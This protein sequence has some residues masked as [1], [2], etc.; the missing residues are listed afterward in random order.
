M[1]KGQSEGGRKRK[2][3]RIGGETERAR[4][5]GESERGRGKAARE[6]GA[7]RGWKEGGEGRGAEARTRDQTP[8]LTFSAALGK[9]PIR[10]SDGDSFLSLGVQKFRKETPS[11]RETTPPTPPRAPAQSAW[12]S[13]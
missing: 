13:L 1:R 6:A 10:Y 9:F 5:R 4:A 8:T 7:P 2:G 12:K 3:S 11:L